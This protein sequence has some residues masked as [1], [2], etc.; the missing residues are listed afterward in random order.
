M[1]VIWFGLLAAG[2]VAAFAGIWW[3]IRRSELL[4]L[5]IVAEQDIQIP[6]AGKVV[7]HLGARSLGRN[8]AAYR[9]LVTAQYEI[10]D[11][12]G[13]AVRSKH[14][15]VRP[16]YPLGRAIRA[17]FLPAP[18]R[19]RLRVEGLKGDEPEGYSLVLT[20]PYLARSMA[21]AAIIPVVLVLTVVGQLMQAAVKVPA[22]YIGEWSAPGARLILSETRVSYR[23]RHGKATSSVDMPLAEFAPDHFST[24]FLFLGETWRIEKPP[25]QVEG[26]W[27]MVVDGVEFRRR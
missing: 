9:R 17:F 19:Y 20:R 8:L 15:S 1:K 6:V 12:T 25:Q 24:R 21:I 27:R 23:G 3:T 26:E 10:L 4:R 16:G 13:R 7:L 18:G 5:S 14:A 11:Q 2:F 22:E